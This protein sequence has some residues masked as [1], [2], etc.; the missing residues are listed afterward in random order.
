[1]PRQFSG[2][3]KVFPIHAL[4]IH[5]KKN[6]HQSLFPVIQKID[7]KCIPQLNVKPENVKLVGKVRKKIETLGQARISK[8]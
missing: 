7:S 1:M 5:V 6:E 8:I 4:I 3:W 2:E